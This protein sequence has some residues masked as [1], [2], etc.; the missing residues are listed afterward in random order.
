MSFRGGQKK[1]TE[2]DFVAAVTARP[3]IRLFLIFGQ[4]TS[5]I[6]DIAARAAAALGADAERVDLDNDQIRK[7]PALL[8]DEAS[9]LSLFGDSRF[10]RLTMRRDE[11]LEAFENLFAAEKR[12][13]RSL[14]Q[15]AI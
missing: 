12:A 11:A 14:P 13:I 1:L 3:D 7:D 8:A 5:A 2:G 6:A 9:S 15:R 10:I 4:D